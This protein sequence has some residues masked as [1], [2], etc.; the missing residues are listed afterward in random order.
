MTNQ[1]LIGRTYSL[2]LYVHDGEWCYALWV[3]GE[4]DHS[5]CLG[6]SEHA[7]SG[8]AIEALASELSVWPGLAA[9]AYSKSGGDPRHGGIQTYRWTAEG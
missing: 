5:D 7:P 2:N 8:L 6:V 3:D 4:Y 9:A 1:A